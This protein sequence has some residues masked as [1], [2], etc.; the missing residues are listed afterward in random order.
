MGE[1]FL[2]ATG[3]RPLPGGMSAICYRQQLVDDPYL[4]HRVKSYLHLNGWLGLHMTGGINVASAPERWEWLQAAYRIFQTMG[5]DTA[6]LI[7]RDEIKAMWPLMDVSDVLG[8]LYDVHEGH[9]DT[10]GTT[11]AYA[12]AARKRG[13][14]II[15]HNRVLEL[16]A[17]AHGW[18]VVTEKGTISCET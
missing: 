4:T 9:V 18:D 12:G 11:Y 1:E 3:N 2:A 13:A 16:H 6:R 5:I 7:T 14:T 8:G 15:E 10:Y 17:K